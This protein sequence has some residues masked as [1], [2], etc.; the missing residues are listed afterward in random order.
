MK[1]GREENGNES[2]RGEGERERRKR[3]VE[4]EMEGQSLFTWV[5]TIDRYLDASQTP[6]AV[7]RL[8]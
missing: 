2:E 7:I 3:R 8:W 4:V 5:K 6:R 1:R